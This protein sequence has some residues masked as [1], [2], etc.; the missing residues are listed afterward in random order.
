MPQ[1]RVELYQRCIEVLL[2]RWDVQGRIENIYDTKAKEKILRKVALEAH[3][4]GKRSFTKD[5]LL[6][7]ISEYLPEVRIKKDE[8]GD[9][10]NEIVQ[11]NVL[12]KEISIGVYEF[13][14]LSFQE[15]LVALELREKKDYGTLLEHLYDPWWEEVV[16]LFAGFGRDATDLILKIREKEKTDERF[17][18]NI[19]CRN[20]SL[21]GKCIADADYTSIQLRNQITNDLWSLYETAEFFLLK[22]RT[23]K[24][25]SLIKPDSIIDLVIGKLKDKDNYVRL[26]AAEALGE[27]GSERAVDPLI[28]ALETDEDSDVREWA[29]YGLGEIGSERAVDSLIKALETDE[30]NSIRRWAAEALGSTES[31]RAVDSL[32]KALE[33]DEDSS[34]REMATCALVLTGSERAVDSLIKALETDEGGTDEDN[35]VRGNVAYWLGRTGSKRAVDPLIKA[36]E[37]DEG[38]GYFGKVKDSAFYSLEI[39][40]RKS[41]ENFLL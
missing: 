40:D 10:L 14:H 25:I 34:V 33:T 22:Q 6:E 19:F 4:Q 12:L 20:L 38:K 13:L 37:T 27:T 29:A 31:E 15:Y 2:S 36:L 7:K 1:R 32:I 23:M 9:V 21:L 11:R 5:E 8:A 17:K 18:E 30:D 3:I 24:I 39:I 28:K 35:I 16:L 26:Y 41:K